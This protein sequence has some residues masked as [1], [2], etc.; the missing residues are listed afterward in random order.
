MT[1]GELGWLLVGIGVGAL[2]TVGAFILWAI[3]NFIINGAMGR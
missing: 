1:A 2:L 3:C